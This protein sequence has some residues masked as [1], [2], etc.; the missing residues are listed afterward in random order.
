[1]PAW[2]QQVV[3]NFIQEGLSCI[4]VGC[5]LW[6]ELRLFHLLSQRLQQYLLFFSPL[7]SLPH[8][9]GKL[10]DQHSPIHFW[11]DHCEHCGEQ[12]VGG[13]NVILQGDKVGV[14]PVVAS[15]PFYFFYVTDQL[16]FV[17]GGHLRHLQSS[18]LHKGVEFFFSSFKTHYLLHFFWLEPFRPLFH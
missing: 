7:Y 16:F 10:L 6:A 18:N 4:P 1:M 11:V 5:Y 17:T 9:T 15:C 8:E 13:E 14:F 2:S 12:N 3:H